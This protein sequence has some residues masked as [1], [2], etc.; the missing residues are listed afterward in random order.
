MLTGQWGSIL[1]KMYL[2]KNEI[3]SYEKLGQT[4]WYRHIQVDIDYLFVCLFVCLFIC[5]FNI[6]I[7]FFTALDLFY[8]LDLF[9]HIHIYIFI[10]LFVCLFNIVII[11]LY[12]TRFILFYFT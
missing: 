10:Y 12:C 11:L 4:D 9:T 6:F 3:R 7:I 5:L 2:F 1:L 8:L